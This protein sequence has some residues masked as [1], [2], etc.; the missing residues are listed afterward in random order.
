[1]LSYLYQ[2]L[3]AVPLWEVLLIFFARMVEVAF[4]TLSLILINKGFRNLG[5]FLSFFEIIIW[6]FVAS[7]VIMGLSEAPI[8]ALVYSLGFSVGVYVGSLLEA[9]IAVGRVLVQV[10]ASE[11]LAPLM[12]DSLRNLGYGVTTIDAQGKENN[13]TVLMIFAQRL[14]KEKILEVVQKIDEKA[15]VVISVVDDLKGGFYPSWRRFRP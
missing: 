13:K 1:M 6:T 10:I 9:R 4:S 11:A 2:V 8:K 15:L 5:S 12:V 3:T 14:K 7:R